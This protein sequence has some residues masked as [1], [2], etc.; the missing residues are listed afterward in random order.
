MRCWCVA[1]SHH[2]LTTV[3]RASLPPARVL[4][5]AARGREIISGARISAC[6]LIFVRFGYR[7]DDKPETIVDVRSRRQQFSLCKLRSLSE[8]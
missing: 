8:T 6:A 2:I 4:S 7:H 5:F 3:W 1:R